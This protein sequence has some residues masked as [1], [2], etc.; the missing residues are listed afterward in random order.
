MKKRS[1]IRKQKIQ[2]NRA[3]NYQD[4]E[5]WDLEFWQQQTPEARLSALIAIRKDAAKVKSSQRKKKS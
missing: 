5:S 4:A 2:A 1:D 3:V